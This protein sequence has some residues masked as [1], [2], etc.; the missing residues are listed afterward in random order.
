MLIKLPGDLVKHNPKVIAVGA[1]GST[2]DVMAP[3]PDNDE[4][5]FGNYNGV[6]AQMAAHRVAGPALVL[7]KP[8]AIAVLR[9]IGK[10][11]GD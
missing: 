3:K 9:S 11:W 6:L 10:T 7:K 2:A 5:F 4:F 1:A 8:P